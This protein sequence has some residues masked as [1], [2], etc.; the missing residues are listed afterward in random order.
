MTIRLDGNTACHS[1]ETST[2]KNYFHL[3]GGTF[4]FNVVGWA[5]E[6]SSLV[7]DE[8]CTNYYA[9]TFFTDIFTRAAV[10]GTGKA[11]LIMPKDN[12]CK[13]QT[14]KVY[15]KRWNEMVWKRGKCSIH[16]FSLW[17]PCGSQKW[18]CWLDDFF[19]HFTAASFDD[20]FVYD[21]HTHGLHSFEFSPYIFQFLG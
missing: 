9:F 16:S 15:R 17:L 14:R 21:A 1:Q 19:L 10:H 13:C 3:P 18:N 5:W 2:L 12:T 7:H 4:R 11:K 6:S 8:F 20:G